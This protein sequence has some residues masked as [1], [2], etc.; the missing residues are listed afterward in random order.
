MT[1][2]LTGSDASMLHGEQ[3]EAAAFAMELL[4]FF[5]SALGAPSLLDTTRAHVRLRAVLHVCPLPDALRPVFGEQIA[6]GESNAIVF[7]N[8]LLTAQASG[9]AR[10]E[11][12]P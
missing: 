1:L 2:A 6:W 9:E 4:A 12:A 3:G 11:P 8:L 10:L 7:A 5:A